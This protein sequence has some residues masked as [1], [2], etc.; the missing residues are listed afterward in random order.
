MH[1]F[2]ARCHGA[3]DPT[4]EAINQLSTNGNTPTGLMV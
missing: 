1:R 3:T 4:G 2:K